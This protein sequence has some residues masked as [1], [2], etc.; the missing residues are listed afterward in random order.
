MRDAH[1]R[2]VTR[3]EVS[4]DFFFGGSKRENYPDSPLTIKA[5]RVICEYAA[6]YGMAFGASVVF[7]AGI[8]AAAM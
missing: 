1:A 6:R 7:A 4:Y 3:V 5:Y 2:G 8:W